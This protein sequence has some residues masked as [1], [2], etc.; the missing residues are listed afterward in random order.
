MQDNALIQPVNRKNLILSDP[1]LLISAEAE[2]HALINILDLKDIKKTKLITSKVYMGQ[3]GGRS[4]SLIGPIIGAPYAVLILEEIIAAGARQI[5]FVGRCGSLS[6][7]VEIGHCIVPDGSYIDEGTSRCYPITSDISYPDMGYSDEVFNICNQQGQMVHKGKIW[8]TDGLYQETPEK[9]EAYQRK[10]AIAVEMETSAL[11]TVASY[12]NV[13]ISALL[14]VSDHLYTLT[15]T[16]GLDSPA[17]K[18]GRTNINQTV[19]ML[20]DK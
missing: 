1:V 15:W 7:S 12:R 8:C 10:N 18:K 20:V 6:E 2:M 9:I 14:I 4:V 3:R 19:R 5:L 13:S 11:F 17:F 16:N